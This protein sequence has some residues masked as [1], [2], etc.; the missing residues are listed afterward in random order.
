MALNGTFIQD[1]LFTT[2]QRTLA[3]GALANNQQFLA[4]FF[5]EERVARPMPMHSVPG[6]VD[7]F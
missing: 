1:D 5:F 7:H 6:M 4:D 3:A 2:L